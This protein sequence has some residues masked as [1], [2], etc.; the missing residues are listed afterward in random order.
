MFPVV[1]VA[2]ASVT[3]AW[4]GASPQDVEEQIVT[5][6]MRPSP[7]SMVSIELHRLRMKARAQ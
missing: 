5:R 7:I 3:V 6:I 4:E 1:P 2:G